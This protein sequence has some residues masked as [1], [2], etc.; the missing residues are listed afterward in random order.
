MTARRTIGYRAGIL[1]LASHNSALLERTCTKG[2]LLDGGKVGPMGRSA[3]WCGNTTT[4]LDGACAS[5]G[6]ISAFIAPGGGS[7]SM[8][9]TA[10]EIGQKFLEIYWRDDSRFSRRP[11]P[12]RRLAFTWTTCA[13][14]R[15]PAT[16]SRRRPR[17][18]P[19]SRCCWIN[20]GNWI[21][22]MHEGLSG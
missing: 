6:N 10:Y 18:C 11:A 1:V 22:A 9:D 17:P 3:K 16:R 20:S 14:T 2:M 15:Q 8:H 4:G 7:R 19:G 13:S 5:G 21:E 12:R